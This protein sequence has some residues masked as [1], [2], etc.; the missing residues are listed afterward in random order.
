MTANRTFTFVVFATVAAGCD[1]STKKTVVNYNLPPPDANGNVAFMLLDTGGV[2]TR[3]EDVKPEKP[4][5]PV[6]VVVAECAFTFDPGG[7]VFGHKIFCLSNL[8]RWL[9]LR[10][11]SAHDTE[12]RIYSTLLF[13][14]GK[15]TKTN[16]TFQRSQDLLVTLHFVKNPLAWT[17]D[18]IKSAV[19]D[20][21]PI[22]LSLLVEAPFSPYHLTLPSL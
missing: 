22:D 21:V 9:V 11:T 14:H 7:S 18:Q 12:L 15:N 6:P 2:A 3:I 17:E 19:D 20:T 4:G 10:I 8:N 13:S 5:D 1:F 16:V